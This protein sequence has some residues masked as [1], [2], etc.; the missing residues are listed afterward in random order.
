MFCMA[1]DAE[2]ILIS[3]GLRF[4]VSCELKFRSI[5]KLIDKI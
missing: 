5:L 4:D 3:H 2:G 1:D